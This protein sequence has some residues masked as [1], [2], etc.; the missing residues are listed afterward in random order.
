MHADCGQF[1]ILGLHDADFFGATVLVIKQ[2]FV[3]QIHR[4]A[5]GCR[6][7]FDPERNPARLKPSRNI[8]PVVAVIAR[9]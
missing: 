2:T 8:E 3:E 1:A 7:V 6:V 9:L 5:I 4:S